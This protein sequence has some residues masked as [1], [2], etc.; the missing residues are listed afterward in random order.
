MYKQII[1]SDDKCLDENGDVKRRDYWGMGWELQ[2]TGQ[3]RLL[4]GDGIEVETWMIRRMT[5]T[6]WE[7]NMSG[8]WEELL[9]SP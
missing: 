1:F 9:P 7:M 3:R 2:K 6:A 5:W 8:T 4:W